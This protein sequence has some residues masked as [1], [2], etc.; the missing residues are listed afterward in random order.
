MRSLINCAVADEFDAVVVRTDFSDD[1]AWRVVTDKLAE[2]WG[3]AGDDFESSNHFV[4]DPA[5]AGATP[6][7]ILAALADAPSVVFLADAA[8]LR[9][10][11]PL[12]AVWTLTAADFP[13]DEKHYED[14]T[15]FG[16]DFRLVPVAVSEM[17]TNLALAN[18]D[19][20]E[21]SSAATEDP[22]RIHRGFLAAD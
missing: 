6:D 7:E 1:A 16:R 11:H 17:H 20:S 14:E 13:E 4:D 8:T 21:F 12:L 3:D 18:M 9:A 5:Y 2:P 10:P 19:F 15:Q 22:E